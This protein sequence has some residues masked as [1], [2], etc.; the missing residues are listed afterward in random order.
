[1]ASIEIMQFG[2]GSLLD[3]HTPSTTIDDLIKKAVEAS[4]G[5]TNPQHHFAIGSQVDNKDIIQVTSVWDESQSDVNLGSTL[6]ESSFSKSMQ[7]YHVALDRSAFGTNGPV[8]ANVVEFVQCYFPATRITSEFQ[9]QIERDFSTFDEIFTQGAKGAGSLAWGWVVE[10]QEHEE[11]KGEMA[12]CFFVARGWESMD[13]FEQ[14]VKTAAYKEA[15][16]ILFAWN[17]PFKM[18]SVGR[19]V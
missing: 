13:F 12:K 16:P 7:S 11:I 4:K 3:A 17:A 1:M 8:T 15:I 19:T 14:S 6:Q 9:N 10:E 5:A 18:V 2:A